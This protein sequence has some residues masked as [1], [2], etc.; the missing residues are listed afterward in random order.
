ML[1]EYGDQGNIHFFLQL[2]ILSNF[3]LKMILF[4]MLLSSIL[5]Y[6]FISSSILIFQIKKVFGTNFDHKCRDLCYCKSFTLKDK[7]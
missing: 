7:I 5:K 4:V 3:C 1:P 2:D 6:E